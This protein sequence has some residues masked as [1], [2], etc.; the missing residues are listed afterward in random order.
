MTQ[1]TSSTVLTQS[2]IN[3]YVWPVTITNSSDSPII[4]Q[5]SENLVFSNSVNKFF[6]INSDNI[7][8]EGNSFAINFS[9]ILLYK[10]LLKNNPQNTPFKNIVIQNLNLT[11]SHN[12]TL[13]KEFGWFGKNIYANWKI[14]HCTSSGPISQKSGGFVYHNFLSGE[15]LNSQYIGNLTTDFTAGIC[16]LNDGKILFCS[17]VGDINSNKS[18]GIS[19]TNNGII[20]DFNQGSTFTINGEY[21]AGAVYENNGP[22]SLSESSIKIRGNSSAGICIL[23]NNGGTIINTKLTVDYISGKSSAGMCTNNYGRL[24]LSAV[25]ADIKNGYGA[26]LFNHNIIQGVVYRGDILKLDSAGICFENRGFIRGCKSFGNLRANLTFGICTYNKASIQSSSSASILIGEKTAGLVGINDNQ[27]YG[28]VFN[29]R[30]NSRE[31]AGVCYENKESG[32]IDKTFATA[33][34]GETA[35]KSAGIA[36]LSYGTLRDSFY[37]GDISGE[38][39]AGISYYG[40]IVQNCYAKARLQGRN[41]AGLIQ[42]LSCDKSCIGN[43]YFFGEIGGINSC[44]LVFT[45]EGKI[46]N[47]YV[48]GAIT[49]DTGKKYFQNDYA[50]DRKLYYTPLWDNEIAHEALL[51]IGTNP[52]DGSVW[53]DVNSDFQQP[54]QLTVF[55]T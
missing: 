45:G 30:I 43:C 21:S 34:I 27:I 18:A 16:H 53:L 44:G 46:S 54:Y 25:N 49:S 8:F 1:I 14:T 39:C 50:L 7:I 35:I 15:I 51:S 26:C 28:C 37:V 48:V 2:L 47:C 32:T 36:C 23:N 6:I 33:D 40:I 4:I 41:N 22:V 5:L 55:F 9:N 13:E 42:Q 19:H 12:S 10:G 52:N 20:K 3:S 31:S 24:C 38:Y 29:G 17:L 11:T